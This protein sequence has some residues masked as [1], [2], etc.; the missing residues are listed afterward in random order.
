[1]KKNLEIYLPLKIYLS[2]RLLS[3]LK[4]QNE[5]TVKC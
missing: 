2:L 5:M 4:G 3:F 1:M